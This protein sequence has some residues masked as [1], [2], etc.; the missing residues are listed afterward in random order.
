MKKIILSLLIFILFPILAVA[1]LSVTGN[2]TRVKNGRQNQTY[3]EV[4]KI[5][6][7]GDESESVIIYLQD[8]LFF[9]DGSTV[10]GEPGV[11]NRSNSSWITFIPKTLTIK[12]NEQADIRIRVNIPDTA[13][14]S[15]TYWSM[16]LIEQSPQL[17]ETNKT[18]AIQQVLRFGIQI[19][20][21]INTDINSMLSFSNLVL[22][23]NESSHI[24]TLDV[25]NTGNYWLH[26]EFYAELYDNLGNYIKRLDYAKSRIY[27]ST[28]IQCSF[29]F[30]EIKEGRYKLLIIADCGNNNVFGGNYT[31]IVK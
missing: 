30:D 12:P 13:E 29:K 8:Y 9:A 26:P 11:N 22:N 19:V 24:L 28:S 27:P 21:N 2:L 31:L 23:K 3:E 7:E 17:M 4:V 5:M 20:S 25:E 15:G 10:Y 18:I 14:L 16:L 6:N 1:Q